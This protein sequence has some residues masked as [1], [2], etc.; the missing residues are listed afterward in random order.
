V[1]SVWISVAIVRIRGLKDEG[2]M[3]QIK[4]DIGNCK[5]SIL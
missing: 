3:W 4:G 1:F 5:N 2:Y